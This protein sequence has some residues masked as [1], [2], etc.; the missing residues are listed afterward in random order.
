MVAGSDVR[1]EPLTNSTSGVT[2]LPPSESETQY[3]LMM[4][5][6]RD[7]LSS[8]A[9][10]IIGCTTGRNQENILFSE[11]GKYVLAHHGLS[12]SDVVSLVFGDP[13][14]DPNGTISVVEG[15][16]GSLSCSRSSGTNISSVIVTWTFGAT[17]LATS[18][19]YLNYIYTNIMLSQSG[20]YS[21]TLEHSIGSGRAPRYNVTRSAT[22]TINV[23]CELYIIT[24]VKVVKI[25]A[26]FLHCMQVVCKTLIFLELV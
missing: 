18:N 2:I 5:V 10:T 13:V 25:Y 1:P 8:T 15:T 22:V 21:C 20:E 3:T 23:Q 4:P 19:D 16:N 7:V 26:L 17:T 6:P 11:L 9:D 12:H 24:L 14:L